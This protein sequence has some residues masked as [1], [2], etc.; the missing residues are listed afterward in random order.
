MAKYRSSSTRKASSMLSSLAKDWE[1]AQTVA[2][3]EAYRDGTIADD[4]YIALLRQR[5]LSA[6]QAGAERIQ[7]QI[8]NLTQSVARTKIKDAI[9]NGSK[10]YYDLALFEKG[11]LDTM[12][13]GSQ[14]YINQDNVYKAARDNAVIAKRTEMN[15]AKQNGTITSAEIAEQEKQMLGLYVEDGEQSKGYRN[16]LYRVQDAQRSAITDAYRQTTATEDAR[17]N[18]ELQNAKAGNDVVK[19]SR[20]IKEQSERLDQRVADHPD[21]FQ[22]IVGRNADGSPIY[23]PSAD[24]YTYQL[25]KNSLEQ[26]AAD[27]QASYA[28]KLSRGQF[29]SA[30]KEKSGEYADITK[31]IEE[32]KQ[33]RGDFADLVAD[34]TAYAA[35]M[36]SLYQKKADAAQTLLTV[37]QSA[38][39]EAQ[40]KYATNIS[41]LQ[42]DILKLTDPT[43]DWALANAAANGASNIIP[44][45]GPGGV[46]AFKDV[47][48]TAV[49]PDGTSVNRLASMASAATGGFGAAPSKYA[50]FTMPGGKTQEIQLDP[51]S[52]ATDGDNQVVR[53]GG[54][55]YVNKNAKD[56]TQDQRFTPVTAEEFIDIARKSPNL[57]NNSRLNIDQSEQ[58]AIKQSVQGIYDEQFGGINPDKADTAADTESISKVT[59][60]PLGAEQAATISIEPDADKRKASGELLQGIEGNQIAEAARIAEEERLA[61]EQRKA[62]EEK[63]AADAA[64][65]AA[66]NEEALRVQQQQ[67][68]T[69]Q[70][71][72]AA[73]AALTTKKK[74][75]ATTILQPTILG[76]SIQRA[77]SVPGNLTQTT[78]P[79]NAGN[80]GTAQQGGTTAGSQINTGLGS[81]LPNIRVTGAPSGQ[82]DIKTSQPQNFLSRIRSFL[83]F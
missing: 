25:R 37:Y 30:Q 28:N 19:V 9:D 73:N 21:M 57:L 27:Y 24:Y 58:D 72:A 54:Q 5:K 64:A 32:L 63:A 49:N 38:S 52:I 69:A 12:T 16:Q 43:G 29:S 11:L 15:Q 26:E 59:D 48:N 8:V 77:A 40:E 17:F 51:N 68:Q 53:I 56:T 83:R 3:D 1:A 50:V 66:A 14:A 82:K 44:Y 31:Q 7:N 55:Y 80:V 46:I 61:E 42:T 70:Q 39:P 65:A 60:K 22:D 2:Q 75:T 41:G 74:K 78:T 45:V 10:T 81:G 36:A 18:L 79:Q 23:Q 20:L 6:N 33:G 67:E 62:E 47:G 76:A 4:D 13:P 34:P 71:A 35:K